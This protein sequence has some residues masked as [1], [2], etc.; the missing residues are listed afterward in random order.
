MAYEAQVLFLILSL[1]KAFLEYY[2]S[3]ILNLYYTPAIQQHGKQIIILW[4]FNFAQIDL[5][6]T[7]RK[8]V[9]HSIAVVSL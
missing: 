2:Y 8:H 1:Y 4:D 9:I 3:S 7:W 6:V 5:H